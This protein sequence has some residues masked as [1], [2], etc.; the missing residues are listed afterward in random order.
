MQWLHLLFLGYDNKISLVL[1]AHVN[2]FIIDLQ[3]NSYHKLGSQL[4]V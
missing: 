4:T 3:R 1:A 2:K